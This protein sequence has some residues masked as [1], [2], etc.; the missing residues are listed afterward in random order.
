MAIDI[1]GANAYFKAHPDW[2]IW[3]DYDLGRRMGAIELAKAFLSREFGHPMN[4]DEPPYQYGDVRR[5]DR[6]VY[7]QAIFILN[8]KGMTG[9]INSTIPSLGSIPLEPEVRTNI[10]KGRLA[11]MALYWLNYIGARFA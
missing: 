11:P 6:A 1:H 5:E 10:H 2:K 9:G 7:E 3:D 4:E 8:Q